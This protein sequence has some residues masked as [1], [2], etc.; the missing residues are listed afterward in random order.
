MLLGF[1]PRAAGAGLWRCGLGAGAKTGSSDGAGGLDCGAASAGAARGRD[2]RLGGL[3]GRPGGAPIC[4]AG[5]LGGGNAPRG[6]PAPWR[7]SATLVPVPPSEL[8]VKAELVPQKG[9]IPC[10]RAANAASVDPAR[11]ER[12]LQKPP[13]SPCAIAQ[14]RPARGP[15]PARG[16]CTGRRR[17]RGAPQ[18]QA[19]SRAAAPPAAGPR[20][21][22]AARA[23]RR[24][25][26][27]LLLRPTTA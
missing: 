24:R 18:Q 17:R 3:G 5:L 26:L 6:P 8:G 19:S 7:A 20:R 15:R 23:S 16:A 12:A 10:F 14:S 1:G 21:R 2:C 25:P 13:P 11:R 4:G 9:S 22:A 27:L